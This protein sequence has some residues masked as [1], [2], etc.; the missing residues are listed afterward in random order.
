MEEEIIA[1]KI[2]RERKEKQLGSTS[3]PVDSPRYHNSLSIA[4]PLF[5]WYDFWVVGPPRKDGRL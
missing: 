3:L 2:M 5:L 1:L 4:L